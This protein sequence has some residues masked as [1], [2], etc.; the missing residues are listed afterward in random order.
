[1][2]VIFELFLRAFHNLLTYCQRQLEVISEN[3]LDFFNDE[4]YFYLSGCVNKQNSVTGQRL[5]PREFHE[6]PFI[7]LI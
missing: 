3:A 5:T 7:A 2:T 4:A 6:R 1:M